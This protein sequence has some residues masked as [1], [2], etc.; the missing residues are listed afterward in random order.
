GFPNSFES[1]HG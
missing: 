1:A